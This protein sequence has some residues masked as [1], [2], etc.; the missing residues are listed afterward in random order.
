MAETVSHPRNLQRSS[1]KVVFDEA[2]KERIN[3]IVKR[4][5]GTRRG[6][7]PRRS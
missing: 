5:D 1:Q 2:Q 4:G 3:E 7:G 6:R